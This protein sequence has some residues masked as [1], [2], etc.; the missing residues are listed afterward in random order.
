MRPP[1]LVLVAFVLAPSHSYPLNGVNLIGEGF[2]GP[3][4]YGSQQM[5]SAVAAAKDANVSWVCLSFVAAYTASINSTGPFYAVPGGTPSG[6]PFNNA[7]TPT[8]AG[9]RSTIQYA[10]S[11][12]LKVILRPMIDPDWRLPWNQD[13][14]SRGQ[15]GSHFNSTEW[16]SWFGSYQA[17]LAPWLAMAQELSVD[18]FCMGAELTASESQS[19]A[20]LAVAAQVREAYTV[21]G[22]IV[23]YSSV[24]EGRSGFPW[25]ISDFVAVDVY[26]QLELANPDPTA[27]TVAELVAAWQP[28]L[29][30]LSSL[31]QDYGKSVLLA[32]TGI[33]SANKSGIYLEPWFFACYQYPANEGVQA[34]YYEALFQT[35]WAQPWFAGV[36]FWKWALEGGP[37]D[38]T[39]FPLNKSAAQVMAAY[40]GRKT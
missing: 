35:A 5:G 6:A 14:T 8:P 4:P 29:N 9:V 16:A 30:L 18:G 22:G 15:I 39:F 34:K 25:N 13:G 37:N 33:C 31:A 7:S 36:F 2:E 10:L 3:Y 11:I 19:A 28:T 20:W 21:P 24:L 38:T 23:Y 1:S 40:Y 32:E 26:P 12:G 17:M 27:A